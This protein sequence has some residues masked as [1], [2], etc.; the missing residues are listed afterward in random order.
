LGFA[1]LVALGARISVP[2]APIPLT[3]QVPFVLLA[4]AF[5]GPRAGAASMATYLAAGALGL[6][7]FAAG[8]GI[9]YLLG[10]TGGY[11]VGFVPAAA[12]VG[13]LARRG[14]RLPRLLLA[15]T[16][17]VATIHLLGILHLS[18]VLGR[19]PAETVQTGLLPFLPGDALKVAGAAALVAAWRGVRRRPEA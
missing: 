17:A 2:L 4:G 16:A 9:A 18:L 12:L 7:V 6:P 10:P 8:G 3:L 13:A 19:S 1:A 5:L 14:A 11:L 15:M